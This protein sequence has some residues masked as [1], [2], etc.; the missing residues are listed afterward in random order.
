MVKNYPATRWALVGL[1]LAA[2]CRSTPAT[3]R[4]PRQGIVELDQR[5]LGFELPGRVRSV[6]VTRGAAVAADAVVATLDDGLARPVR[7]ARAAEARA[8]EAQ[9]DLVRAGSRREDVRATEV[10]L[11]GARETEAIVRRNHARVAALAKEGSVTPSH[12]DDMEAQL[13]TAEAQRRVLEQ[14]L[15]LQRAGARKE[16]IAAAEA[17]LGAARAA[18]AAE[19]ER[20]TRYAVRA[21]LAGTVLDVHFDP[22]EVVGAGVA[23]V[24][25]ADTRHPY[26]DIFVPE[27][28]MAPVRVGLAATVRVDARPRAYGAHVED[29]ARRTEF[30]PRY[31]FSERERPNLVVRVRVRVDDASGAELPAGVPAEVVLG[32]TGTP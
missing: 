25:M 31:L 8:A 24:T 32:E 10:Q 11:A 15:A 17:R 21:P 26:V 27:G 3:G 18:L 14:R 5:A 9:L 29:V 20:L 1:G 28:A 13:A 6:A 12:L 30:T 16:E 7:D 19:E 22:G 23:V 2:G 4:E